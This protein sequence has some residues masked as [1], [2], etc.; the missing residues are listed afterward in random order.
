[1][2][3]SQH[4]YDTNL[5]PFPQP[6]PLILPRHNCNMSLDS[7]HQSLLDLKDTIMGIPESQDNEDMREIMTDI[8]Q[9]L[10]NMYHH[11]HAL[12]V[13]TVGESN[14]THLTHLTNCSPHC[15][16]QIIIPCSRFIIS[17]PLGHHFQIVS[18]RR[19]EAGSCQQG[20]STGHN[21]RVD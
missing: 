7:A 4:I 10:H 6:T 11:V 2:H 17:H 15:R 13:P 14:K 18:I 8:D 19:Q 1:M 16:E 20:M 5:D 21:L 9:A 3:L 12:V